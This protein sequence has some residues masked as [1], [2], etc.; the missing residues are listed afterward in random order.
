MKGGCWQQNQ[1]LDDESRH[2]KCI[3]TAK[4]YDFWFP[5]EQSYF[6]PERKGRI[7]RQKIAYGI[8]EITFKTPFLAT[9]QHQLGIRLEQGMLESTND[10]TGFASTQSSKTLHRF[11]HISDNYERIVRPRTLYQSPV[12]ME[13]KLS[14]ET[15]VV[16][17]LSS[18]T[19]ADLLI[20][21]AGISRS[22]YF[23]GMVFATAVSKILYKRAL[24]QDLFMYQKPDLSRPSEIER[25][26]SAQSKG[27]D[28]SQRSTLLK[29]NSVKLDH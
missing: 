28:S 2:E 10:W 29:R 23:M 25:K 15:Y 21:L 19:L 4:D 14:K 5:F 20:A 11:F 13:I 24:I 16:Q 9:S 3:E 6:E 7:A 18:N 22:F 17:N 12:K 8:N 1:H 27:L 26:N